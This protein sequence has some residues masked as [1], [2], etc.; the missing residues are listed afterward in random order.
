MSNF[1]PRER[2]YN[3]GIRKCRA[4]K[5]PYA[6]TNQME[7]DYWASTGEFGYYTI[8]QDVEAIRERC[9]SFECLELVGPLVTLKKA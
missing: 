7:R 4:C 5:K 6:L 9:C 8:R 3:A 2:A 1:D